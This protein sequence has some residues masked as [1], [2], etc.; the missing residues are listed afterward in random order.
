[1]R[2]SVSTRVLVPL[3]VL[4]KPETASLGTSGKVPPS[5]PV[6][7][8]T[9]K[10]LCFALIHSGAC[11]TTGFAPSDVEKV[12]GEIRGNIE[13]RC[14]RLKTIA[15]SRRDQALGFDDAPTT[16]ELVYCHRYLR[17]LDALYREGPAED[18]D[19]RRF[20]PAARTVFVD[21]PG[22]PSGVGARAAS[23]VVERYLRPVAEGEQLL[24]IMVLDGPKE[25]AV[26]A[27]LLKNSTVMGFIADLPAESGP[28][29]PGTTRCVSL[30]CFHRI[31]Q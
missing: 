27:E 11:R 13:S 4:L 25:G 20:N 30:L 19:A 14:Q 26:I 5:S 24:P 2:P 17:D 29:T 23:R 22:I 28:G 21:L 9:C 7:L 10:L 6:N 8:Q 1:V 3:A 18:V 31:S 15:E 12:A 16:I